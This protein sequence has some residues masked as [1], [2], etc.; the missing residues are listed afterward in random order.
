MRVRHGRSIGP[1]ERHSTRP[2]VPCATLPVMAQ[3]H[4]LDPYVEWGGNRWRDELERGLDWLGDVGGLRILDVGTRNGRMA[5]WFARAGAKVVAVDVT[6]DAMAEARAF[7]ETHGVSDR[8]DFRLYSGDP[9]ELPT[10]FDVVFAKSVVVLMDI[11][12]AVDGF[13]AALKEGGRI[14]L[15]ENARGPL[16]LHVARVLRRGSLRPH[17]ARYFT[18]ATV[19]TIRTR[20]RVDLEHWAPPVVVIGGAKE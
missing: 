17:G 10:G 6:E 16:P 14:L 1:R 5:T 9:A 20:F 11:E 18:D 4:R 12:G 8:I 15:V 19:A 2:F 3:Q 7:A 13:A